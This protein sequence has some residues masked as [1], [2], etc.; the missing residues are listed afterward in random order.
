MI[1][2]F[3]LIDFLQLACIHA[4]NCEPTSKKK[5]PDCDY[6][7]YSSASGIKSLLENEI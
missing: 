1:Q 2:L 7:S 3:Y 5:N 4:E 6:I